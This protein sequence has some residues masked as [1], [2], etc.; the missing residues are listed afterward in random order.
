M[1]STDTGDRCAVIG[2]GIAGVACAHALAGHGIAVDLIDRGQRLGGRIAAMT[3][4][5]E[6]PWQ[7]R[8]MDIG[9]SYPTVTHPDFQR[10]MDD[11]LVRGLART[12]TNVFHVV[13]EAGARQTQPGPMRYAAPAGLRSLVEDLAAQLPSYVHIHH[14]RAVER[15]AH[16]G[17]SVTVD[18]QSYSAVV[19]AMPDPQAHAL[20][21]GAARRHI[22]TDLTGTTWQPS[23]ALAA[24]Y[25]QRWWPDFAGM[26]VNDD[27][28]IEWIADDGDRRGDGAPV[29]VAHSAAHVARAFYDDP[30]AAAETLISA[31]HAALRGAF[32]MDPSVIPEPTWHIVKRWGLAKPDSPREAPF[33]WNA[34]H[35][36]G[37]AGDGWHVAAGDRS[38]IESAWL[39]GRA[40]GE[41]IA[42]TL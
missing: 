37:V 13:E 35:R 28:A 27:A 32:S 40:L 14:P 25:S 19:L 33:L 23:L 10:L 2:A 3:L 22:A 34:Q 24:L 31:T 21:T 38:R 1:T 4:R 36:I 30:S 15:V 41:H 29:L 6:S 20:L 18:D 26:F 12:W 9:A 39:S 17:A 7:G 16:D 42:T 8:V 5:V 11:W